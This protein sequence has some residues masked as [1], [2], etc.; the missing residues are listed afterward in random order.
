[1][2]G[3]GEGGEMGGQDVTS[4][5]HAW[6]NFREIGAELNAIILTKRIFFTKSFLCETTMDVRT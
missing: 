6:A 4:Q 2:C 1:M 3:G 5:P